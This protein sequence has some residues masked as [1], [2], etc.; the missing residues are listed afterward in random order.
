MGTA[1]YPPLNRRLSLRLALIASLI[2]LLSAG[3]AQLLSRAVAA[4]SGT[5][6]T[7]VPAPAKAQNGLDASSAAAPSNPGGAGA[8]ATTAASTP[9]TTYVPSAAVP[10]TATVPSTA[11]SSIPTTPA[12]TAPAATAVITRTP[13]TSTAKGGDRPLSSTTIAIVVLAALLI[14]A[15]AGWALARQRAFEPLWLVSLR[16]AS[17]EA[18]FRASASWSEFTDWIRIGR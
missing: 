9:T 5:P 14:L 17:A 4:P 8:P 1:M 10:P 15:C 13:A 12:A 2:S 16:H 7:T 6:T 11:T 18:A 3:P